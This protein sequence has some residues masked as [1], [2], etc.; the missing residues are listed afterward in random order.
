MS[1]T[2]SNHMQKTS[3]SLSDER[4]ILFLVGAVQ[5]VNIL[6]FMMVMPLG[7]DYAHKLGITS[8]HLGW[9]GGS[10][11]AAA[12]LA[13][14][15]A[16]LF[17][18]S[19]DRKKALLYCLG[20]LSVATVLGGFA[21]DFGTLIS[22]RIVAGMFGGPATSLAWSIVADVVEPSRR[23]QAMGKVMAAFSI[24][25]IVGVPFGLEM[26]KLNDWRT[27]FFVTGALGLLVWVL[28][29]IRMPS[30]T[31]HLSAQNRQAMSFR[32]LLA[33][34]RNPQYVMTYLYITLAM[35]ASF[36]IVPN[37]AAYVQY[38]LHYPRDGMGWL[39][40]AGGLASFFTMRVTGKMIDRFSATQVS[41]VSNITYIAV[42]WIAFISSLH[43]SV[44]LF[45]VLF[46]FALGMR[47]VSSTTLA[48]KIPVPQERAGFMSVFSCM[49]AVGMAT[50][51][52]LS[53]A[54]LQEGEGSVLIGMDTIAVIA[55]CMSIIVPL[56]ML[57]VERRLVRPQ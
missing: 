46:M 30:L 33:M 24:A 15:L 23:G 45:F 54:I 56:L 1:C 34:F 11:T 28:V 9:V 10:Y 36:M 38:N 43:L 14:I 35:M 19:L 8:S 49:Q 26:A 41:V 32:Y 21:W 13:G 16:S 22:A 25:S 29:Y 55:S 37:L 6:D 42:L 53:S 39:Y 44:T 47:N 18:D 12:A 51:A 17:I 40:F 5:F 2:V 20:G 27:P 57:R 52:F 50:G 48:T 4:S 3:F 7:P 31:L